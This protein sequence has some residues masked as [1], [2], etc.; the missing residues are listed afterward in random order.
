M[1]LLR[2]LSLAAK[3][4][5][6]ALAPLLLLG[7]LVSA[8]IG[9]LGEIGDSHVH[10]QAD[11]EMERRVRAAAM[12]AAALPAHNRALFA[13]QTSQEVM[14]IRAEVSRIASSAITEVEAVSTHETHDADRSQVKGFA[15]ALRS[16]DAAIGKAAEL[17]ARLIA[18]RDDA[19]FPLGQAFDM[20]FEGTFAAIDLEGLDD[21]K[22]EE[23]RSRLISVNGA[24]SDARIA[25][26][27]YLATA[28]AGQMQRVRRAAATG[29]TH[30]RGAL[31]VDV[32]ARM[33]GELEETSQALDQLF[34]AAVRL[35]T[36]TGELAD[37]DRSAT[38]SAMNAVEE[39]VSAVAAAYVGEARAAG[40]HMVEVMGIARN[41]VLVAAG[42][43]AALLIGIAVLTSI[44]VGRPVS[45]ITE[46]LQRIAGGDTGFA[47]AETARRDEFGQIQ[48]AVA[49]LRG[50]VEK[51]FAQG[52]M[53]EQLPVAVMIADPRDGFRIGYMNAETRRVLASV[54]HLLPAKVD[55]LVGQS[56]DIFHRNPS[57][58]HRLLND[59]SRLPHRARIRLADETMDLRINA[60]RDASGAYVG[61]MLVWNLVT[62]QVKLADSF[63]ASVGRVA[64]G[65]GEGA[66]GMKAAA[67]VM[68]EIASD[69]GKR[70]A[71]VAA[72]TDQASSNVQT[73]AASAEELAA[74]VQ[75]ISRQ[76]AESARI[77]SQAAGEARATDSTVAGLSAAA[78]RIGDVVKLIGDIA[79][80]TNLLA[81][82]ATIEAARAGEA[83]KGFAVVASEVK[84]LA[85]QTAKAT[86]EIGAQIGAMQQATEQAVSAIRGIGTT[87]SR[88]NEIAAG[89]AAAVEE[90]GAA[91]HEIA[92]GVQ[93]AA[94]GTNEVSSN[95]GAVS[96]SVEQAGDQAAQ[97][98]SSAHALTDEAT[99]LTEEVERFLAAIRAR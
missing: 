55:A 29:R 6:L 60:L 82:N 61:T 8:V 22:I 89:I 57:H 98:L 65:V 1:S 84:N 27:R 37:H 34:Q 79:G 58:Q 49:V 96:S 50:T 77:A 62:E 74:S 28:D 59:P 87:I 81:L 51:A 13:A 23:L 76:V 32:N 71:A 31:G 20:R 19:F 21:V 9:Q 53:L 26:L 88:M 48:N 33:K 91:T 92:R 52:Q 75:E 97:V 95:I 36:L 38:V 69:T 90:Q 47:L 35:G 67:E 40:Q 72:A 83:G 3:L 11:I 12:T 30:M 4:A 66:S 86:E 99:K 56:I 16:L 64:R 14:A 10:E 7:G 46:Q 24:A 25:A 70:A 45:R 15:A 54:E 39:S 18:T 63:E 78:M 80:Q 73:V 41:T 43:I 93:Q 85:G 2:N 94:A 42:A 17:R 5:L 44:I 68:S